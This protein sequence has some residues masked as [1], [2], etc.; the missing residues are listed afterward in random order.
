M[1]IT[2][3]HRR[4]QSVFVA[5]IVFSLCATPALGSVTVL[6]MSVA[7]VIA[8]PVAMSGYRTIARGT[9]RV[10]WMSL[11]GYFIS[12]VLIDAFI[13]GDLQ[14]SFRA[15]APSSPVLAAAIIAMALDPKYATIT[16]RKLGEWASFAV[17]VSGAL[18]WMIAQTQP[19]WPILGRSVTDIT[20]VNGRLSLFV[21]NPLPFAGAFMT[22]GFVSLLG[23]HERP[24]VSR[25]IAV[26]A[27]LLA[28]LVVAL[29]SQSRGATVAAIPLLGLALWYLRPSRF[30]VL[31]GV[32]A[33]VVAVVLG[34]G[35]G[36]NLDALTAALSRLVRGVA[37]LFGE[38]PEVDSSTWQRLVM[39]RAGIAAW[40]DSPVFGYGISQR[41][42]AAVPYF[43]P[44]FP[45]RYTHLHNTFI[46]HAV[47]GGGVGLFFLCAVLATPFFVNRAARPDQDIESVMH[48]RDRRYFAWMIFL[49]LIG[50]GM[51]GLIL[52]QDV[53]ANFLGT[54]LV[55]HLITQRPVGHP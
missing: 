37:V 53:S 46:T 5:V 23:W 28:I 10:V 47:A 36:G 11:I 26:A 25:V 51:S 6:V 42:S 15:I 49:S 39:Y 45:G 1:S 29:W 27:T 13:H 3:L 52:N 50:I 19:G 33:C 21:G 32:A 44:D 43:P 41:F 7:M 17:L 55:A 18:A 38:V 34:I 20:G 24:L 54:L 16:H 2:G 22:L 48:R 40:W 14:N 12:Y 30:A 31:V 35:L 9:K 8:I 4:I